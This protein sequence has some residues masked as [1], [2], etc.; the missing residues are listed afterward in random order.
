MK[1]N[2]SGLIQAQKD[3]SRFVEY[4]LSSLPKFPAE[5]VEIKRVNAGLK[6]VDESAAAELEIGKNV[7]ALSE[8]G[9]ES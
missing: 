9:D 2:N 1:Q 4:I 5:Y 6:A 7:C 3:D 8:T